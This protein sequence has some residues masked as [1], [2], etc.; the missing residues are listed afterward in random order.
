MFH[1]KMW[2]Y[3]TIKICI[4]QSKNKDEYIHNIDKTWLSKNQ[5]FVK[6]LDQFFI[7]SPNQAKWTY[8]GSDDLMG[9][10]IYLKWNYFNSSQWNSLP[11]LQIQYLNQF[12]A[13]QIH[14]KEAWN[15]WS[16]HTVTH[17]FWTH[18][19]TTKILIS[20]QV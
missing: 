16:N 4:H 12:I 9:N 13:I 17:F 2:L 6:S 18:R 7:I 10:R 8:I 20:S 11:T 19:F 15:N 14:C 5:S 3:K 1:T